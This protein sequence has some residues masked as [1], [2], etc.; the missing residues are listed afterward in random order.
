MSFN[1][2]LLRKGPVWF[3]MVSAARTVVA[4]A[5]YCPTVY[6]VSA[7]YKGTVCY[8]CAGIFSYTFMLEK[9]S[10]TSD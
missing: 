9:D 8:E 10:M 6:N 4:L 1:I 5:T 7:P 3:V 2:D